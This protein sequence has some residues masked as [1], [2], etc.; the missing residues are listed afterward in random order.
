[1]AQT[2][3]P[4]GLN[5]RFRAQGPK[6]PRGE[7]RVKANPKEQPATQR[8]TSSGRPN[9]RPRRTEPGR[10]GR[11]ARATSGLPRGRQG[12]SK[13]QRKRT[14]QQRQKSWNIQCERFTKPGLGRNFAGQ[15]R[16]RYIAP[17]GTTEELQLRKG[18]ERRK[19]RGPRRAHSTR[20]GVE[21]LMLESQGTTNR[22]A[23]I[24]E[25]HLVNAVK[26]LSQSRLV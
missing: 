14:E 21:K 17:N 6:Q 22:Q 7:G 18:T 19:E 26:Q 10:A 25:A 20:T 15:T 16:P 1:M 12:D 23:S 3:K 9:L 8:A 4:K 11:P 13:P 2:A 24:T 5:G